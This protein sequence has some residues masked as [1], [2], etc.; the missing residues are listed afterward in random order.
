MQ[1]NSSAKHLLSKYR[2][3]QC[4]ETEKNQIER[5]W[6][7]YEDDAAGELSEETLKKDLAIVQR[8]IR[9]LNRSR[10]VWYKVAAAAV[11]LFGLFLA[12][13][14]VVVDKEKA[15]SKQV[16]FNDIL[17]GGN[18]AIL[19][20]ASGEEF[21]LDSSQAGITAGGGKISYVNGKTLWKALTGNGSDV[22]HRQTDGQRFHTLITPKGGTYQITLE[23]GT[24]VWL[25]AASSLK[26]PEMFSD[27]CRCVEVEGE[28][29][30]EVSHVVE[31]SER[32]GKPRFMGAPFVVKSAGQAI[33]VLGTRFN[34]RS[35]KQENETRTTL[36]QGKVKVNTTVA[37]LREQQLAP[38]E[39]SLLN[40]NGALTKKY[41]DAEEAISW[42]NGRISLEG[43]PFQVIMGEL[44]RWYDLEIE[45]EG[46]IPDVSFY[47]DVIRNNNLSTV[48][49]LLESGGVSYKLAG[50]KLLVLNRNK[51]ASG[52]GH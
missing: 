2:N 18:K 44:S 11:I 14:Y 40:A 19:R 27:D 33:T 37:G 48:L 36:V 7:F 32:S 8:Q 49:R 4:S 17:P 52:K 47:G 16:A 22:Q 29:Y 46:A 5:W 20:L 26:Y 43:K 3:D 9:S 38:G 15:D 12:S 24:K 41:I 39:Q 45:Y 23:D 42:M 35:Y 6:L 31:K 30:F 13:R 21:R 10:S 34:V 1:D 51:G 50:N 25:N 28:A